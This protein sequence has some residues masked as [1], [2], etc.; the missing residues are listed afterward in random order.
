MSFS[1]PADAKRS[2][3]KVSLFASNG[4]NLSLYLEKCGSQITICNLL[5]TL[6]SRYAVEFWTKRP[7]YSTIFP[8]RNKY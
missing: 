3:S 6:F 1:H 8:I 5:V 4:K 7:Q 2:G